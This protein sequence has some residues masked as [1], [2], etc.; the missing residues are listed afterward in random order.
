MS[1][2]ERPEHTPA[3][4][5]S[6]VVAGLLAVQAVMLVL[7]AW[8]NARVEPR[9]LPI[10]VAGPSPA[11]AQ[12][13]ATMEAEM[14]GAFTVHRVAD[15]A[16][17]R[18]RVE[19]RED[20][21]ALVL[22]GDAAPRLLVA[23]AAS[24]PVATL[25][26][27]VATQA[28]SGQPPIVEDVVPAPV[29]DPQGTGLTMGMLPVILLP[30]VTGILLSITVSS[31]RW[32]LV[33]AVVFALVGGSACA[34]VLQGWIE[35]I[36]GPVLTNA[37]V[38]VLLMAAVSLGIVGFASAGGR[39]G[40][41]LGSLVMFLFGNPFSGMGPGPE[42]LPQPWGDVGQLLPAGAGGQLLRSTAFFDGHAA[43]GKVL[44]LACWVAL[45]LLLAFAGQ[46]LR[47]RREGRAA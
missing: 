36:E 12:M 38:L 3:R 24:R 45:G 44:V 2:D 30:M 28:V 4:R 8:P 21:G 13:A 47:R 11:V 19:E 1:A 22:G 39:P 7:F 34:T 43:G 40:I 9:D 17:A 16:E 20:Y 25:L 32:R 26:Q 31:L 37:A 29:S 41:A 15:E 33:G 46:W 5:A 27:A 18:Q 35:A 10:A 14:P 23:S 42:M 6:L